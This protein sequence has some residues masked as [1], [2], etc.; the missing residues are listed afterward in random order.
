MS[1]T[2]SGLS[3]RL[4]YYWRQISFVPTRLR[5]LGAFLSVCFVLATFAFLNFL[6]YGTINDRIA[7]SLHNEIFRAPSPS[8]NEDGSLSL[9]EAMRMIG[10]TT[11]LFARDYSLGLGWNNVRLC[12]LHL[13]Y[14]LTLYFDNNCASEDA[15]YH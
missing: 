6:H 12:Y 1:P 7:C 9:D 4:T 10:A 8:S 11:G 5:G 15:I 3:S 14:L 2:V 13:P